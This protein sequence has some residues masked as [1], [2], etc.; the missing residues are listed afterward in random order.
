MQEKIANMMNHIPKLISDMRF[1]D[2]LKNH[3]KISNQDDIRGVF[4]YETKGES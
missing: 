3:R 4:I 2:S 1:I